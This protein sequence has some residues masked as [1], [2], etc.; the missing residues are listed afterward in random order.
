MD[1][2]V[3]A[4]RPEEEA[5]PSLKEAAQAAAQM[6]KDSSANTTVTPKPGPRYIEDPES[7]TYDLKSPIAWDDVEY[8]TVKFT[9]M[10]G[11]DIHKFK[12]MALVMD[13]DI[14][15]IHLITGIPIEVVQFM[16]ADDYVEVLERS[17]PFVPARFQEGMTDEETPKESSTEQT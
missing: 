2:I 5:A 16:V 3:T 8:R 11:G 17:V 1:N 13:G 6:A 4:V 9:P 10:K 14:V 7:D 15:A 12:T